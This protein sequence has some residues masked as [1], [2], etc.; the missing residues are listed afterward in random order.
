MTELIKP[1]AA[2]ELKPLLLTGAALQ[3]QKIRSAKMTKV[4]LS[5][6]EV[7]D[8]IMLGIGGF[9]PL[10]SAMNYEDW[11]SV[12]Q[13]MQTR[14]G[15]YWPIPLT[16]S[17]DHETAKAIRLNEEVA[18]VCSESLQVIATMVVEEKYT[19]DKAFQCE[20]I[21]NTTEES[22]PGVKAV[23][24][25]AEVNLA[26]PIKVLS[27]GH[28]PTTFSN[29]YVPPAEMRLMFS[30]RGWQNVLAFQT[31]NP[32][33]RA[34]EYL[35]KIGLEHYDGVL[36]HSLLG[37]VKEG[38]LPASIRIQ[39]INTLLEHYFVKGS[40]IHAG[41][42]LDMRYAGPREALLHAIFR[43][44]YGCS[45]IIIGRDHASVGAYYQPFA[46]QEIFNELPVGVLG[47][48]PVNMEW[49]FW[50]QKC[51]GMSSTRTCPHSDGVRVHLSGTK[52]RQLLSD[53]KPIPEHFSRPEVV[54]ILRAYYESL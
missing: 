19:I 16:I 35:V 21:F 27:Q 17:T 34:H 12:C 36:I 43:Q 25:Q 24:A 29:T 18:L 3:E 1:Y 48:E 46:A 38:D 8:L 23:M 31:R 52:L 33:H 53:D 40:V 47:I 37:N 44:N 51:D 10:D 50:C 5:S 39:A 2:T 49:M 7:N 14:S 54:K 41:Y 30:E 26:G 15:L 20:S 11:R 22:H 42:P 6:I 28:Y 45:H 32:M 4:M 13:S 9:T